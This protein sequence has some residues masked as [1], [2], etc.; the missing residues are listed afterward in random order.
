MKLEY[1]EESPFTG[2]KSVLVE[3]DETT[4]IESKICMDTGYTTRDYWKIGSDAVEQYTEQITQL[5]QDTKFEDHLS[6]QV[7]FLSSMITP[8]AMLYPHGINEH[9]WKWQ[10]APVQSNYR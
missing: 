7:W 5:M 8:H 6:G 3:A 9:N 4:N 1:D 10:V 2:K